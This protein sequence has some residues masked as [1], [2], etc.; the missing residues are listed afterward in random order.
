MGRQ[1]AR[2]NER[3]SDLSVIGADR[4]CGL[5]QHPPD[6]LACGFAQAVESFGRILRLEALEA[7]ATLNGSPKRQRGSPDPLG[8]NLWPDA[9]AFG[10]RLRAMVVRT[11]HQPKTR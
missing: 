10:S 2:A 11:N 4:T 7:G 1:F 5:D 9:S 3:D 6:A 8:D